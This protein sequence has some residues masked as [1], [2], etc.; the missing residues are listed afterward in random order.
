MFDVIVIGA[1]F[2]GL[3]AAALLSKKHRV[4]VL[5]KN[6]F[7]G[8]RAATRTP[9]EW[10][11]ADTKDYKVDFGHH[12]FATNNYLEFVLDKTGARKYS[13]YH[14]INMPLFYKNKKFHK[15]PVSVLEQLRAYPFISFRSK[16]KIKKFLSYV[17]KVSYNEV[18]QKWAYKPLTE[19]YDEFAFDES[20]REL[21]TDGFA[22]GYQTLTNPDK[23]SAGDLILCLKAFQKGVNKYKTPLF[24]AVGGV[25]KIA[26]A[27]AK[28]VE[29]NGGKIMLNTNV[30]QIIL[31]NNEAVGV[32]I[33]DK[34]IRGKKIL[35]TA[36]IYFLL[37][38]IDERKLPSEYVDKLKEARM[39]ATSLF[40][41]IGGAKKPLS[42]KPVGTWILI[43]RS[44][45]KNIDSYYLVYEV[46]EYLQQ[47]PKG[48]YL[49]S[50]AIIPKRGDIVHKKWLVESMIKD[51]SD[52]FPS[53]DFEKDFEWRTTEYFPIVD[54][55][56][57][58]IDWYYERR[59]KNTTPV[60][61]LYAAGDSVHELSSGVD[62][63]VSSA[64]F[65]VEEMTG[66]K[67][68]NLEEFYKI[69]K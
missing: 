31:R 22:A 69:V 59:F 52:I 27:L 34:E 9:K 14:L 16:L 68:L 2:T 48:R 40:L 10:N 30:T 65:A 47:A 66:E 57:R 43:P 46:G 60:K 49:V 18:M 51:M 58:T 53:F 13:N 54:G 19:L 15:P 36:P 8:G 64:I 39:K 7:V 38:L 62:G 3:S 32:K 37:D 12:V 25:G 42:K 35:F 63:C 20:A 33:G 21:F 55:L 24:G 6:G 26:E 4:L 29:E 1:G 61:N 28:V 17:E 50:F 67:I 56:E 41:I 11:W 5:E 44:E 23:N 45:V